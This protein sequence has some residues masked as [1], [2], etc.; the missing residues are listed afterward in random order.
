MR[1][2]VRPTYSEWEN[3]PQ[4]LREAMTLVRVWTDEMRADAERRAADE[5]RAKGRRHG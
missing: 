5:A 3:M 2:E 4:P 1:A